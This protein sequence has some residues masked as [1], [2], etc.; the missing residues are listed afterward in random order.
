VLRLDLG[1]WQE[2]N[3]AGTI[4]WR[5]SATSSWEHILD[6]KQIYDN[7]TAVLHRLAVLVCPLLNLWYVTVFCFVIC[8]VHY[9]F[10]LLH[11]QISIVSRWSSKDNVYL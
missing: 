1:L 4:I 8:G 6:A 7:L 3:S 10:L 2:M 9:R 11:Q 5:H